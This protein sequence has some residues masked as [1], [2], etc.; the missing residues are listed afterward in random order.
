VHRIRHKEKEEREATIALTRVV[1]AAIPAEIHTHTQLGRFLNK[2][3]RRHVAV[4]WKLLVMHHLPK[5]SHDG[6]MRG[7]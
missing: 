4:E 5:R 7:S 1:Q 2:C 3:G 6:F